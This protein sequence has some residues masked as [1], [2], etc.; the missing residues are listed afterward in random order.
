ME[1]TLGRNF[2]KVP[3]FDPVNIPREKIKDRES[4]VTESKGIQVTEVMVTNMHKT[5]KKTT[6]KSTL[7]FR[8]GTVR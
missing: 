6:I 3:S 7:S 2:K 4:L 1:R 5:D 8:S